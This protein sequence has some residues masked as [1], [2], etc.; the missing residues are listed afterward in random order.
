MKISIADEIKLLCPGAALGILHY[1]TKVEESSEELIE[2]F[3]NKL[4]SLSKEYTFETIV[5][6]PHIMT[7][8]Q[9]YKA[10][11]KSPHEYRNAAEAMLRRIVK[12]T[13]LYHINNVIE[14]NNYISV[15]SGYSIGSYDLNELHGSV[16]LQ[17]AKKDAHYYGI[18]K[19]N[20][21]IEYLPVLY[22]EIGP[23]GN[24]SSDS[25]RAMIQNGDRNICSVIYSFDGREEVK[26]WIEQ[27]S[28]MLEQYCGVRGI[29]TWVV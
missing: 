4:L 16:Q 27:F 9:A 28:A 23:F 22:D 15:S 20:V 21:N 3:E 10:L 2:V 19:G 5:K 13:G 8:R 14:I 18:G 12:N 17:R 6:N 29:E 11:G 26:L 24:P 7:T 1:K 25:R